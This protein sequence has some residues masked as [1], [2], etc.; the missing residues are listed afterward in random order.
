LAAAP[1]AK[2]TLLAGGDVNFG[3]LRGQELLR[4]PNRDDFASLRALYDAADLRFVN[5]ESQLSD[6]G[7]ETVSPVSPLV[8]TGPPGGADALARGRIDVVSFANNHAWDYGRDA[9]FETLAELDRVS[10]RYVGAGRDRPSAYAPLLVRRNGIGV[11][12]IAATAIW[13]QGPLAGHPAHEHVM[14]ATTE[15]L[16]AAVAEARAM[17]GADVVVVSV[18]GGD[19]YV[20][21]PREGLRVLL[22]SA[23]AAGADVVLG[24]H[25]HVVQRIEIIDGKPL[26]YSLGNLLMRM[27]SGRPW[28]EFGLL[29]RVEL[30]PKRHPVAAICPVRIAGLDA[31]ALGSDPNRA[32]VEPY[33]RARFEQLL[34]AGAAVDRPSS[35]RLGPFA[36]DGCAPVLPA[37]EPR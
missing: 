5:L 32:T 37:S 19:E 7:G 4:D 1:A 28:T 17:D 9:F 33:F 22:R 25:P 36:A 30:R 2:V 3:Q 20:D 34:A 23:M 13:N 15:S 35:A 29:V 16:R 27:A 24:H 10:V 6:Q 18:H 11:A 31:I 12:F 21:T 26:F 14:E 8:F